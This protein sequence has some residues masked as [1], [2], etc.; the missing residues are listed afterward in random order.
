MGGEAGG[1]SGIID[2][3]RFDDWAGILAAQRVAHKR[4]AEN[5]PFEIIVALEPGYDRCIVEPEKS[6]CAEFPKVKHVAG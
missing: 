5:V 2:I 1:W 4:S 3:E 6:S